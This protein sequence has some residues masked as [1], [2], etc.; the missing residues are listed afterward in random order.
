MCIS[1]NTE[2]FPLGSITE[3]HWVNRKKKQKLFKKRKKPTQ[4]SK[5]VFL[6]LKNKF[7]N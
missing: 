3:R 2:I 6:Q 5:T 7:K 1:F 4:H